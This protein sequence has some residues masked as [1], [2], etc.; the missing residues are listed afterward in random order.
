MWHDQASRVMSVRMKNWTTALLFLAA[1][2]IGGSGRQAEGQ[3]RWAYP[4]KKAPMR[5]RLVAVAI[6][7]PRS[8]FFKS[9]EVFIA[10]TEI[11][12]EE[13]SLIKLVFTFLPYEP[14]LS[15]S[16]FDYSVVHE[17]SAW[18]DQNCDQ[19]IAQL[20][21]RSLPDHHEPLIYS[22]NVPREDLDR[23]RSPLPCYETSA[24]EYIKSSFEPVAPPKPHGPVLEVR[25]SEV[26][27]NP[28]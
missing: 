19:T 20:K 11:G 4:P 25:P 12:H 24:Y 8:S 22:R 13:W 10:E 15:E 16:G 14:R 27:P 28:R 21:A 2:C 23:R 3:L 17:V 26:R 6:S 5:V 18:R 9:S 1:T 7:L